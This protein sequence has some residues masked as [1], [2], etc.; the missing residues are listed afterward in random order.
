MNVKRY[1]V[2]RRIQ[3]PSICL[4]ESKHAS[5]CPVLCNSIILVSFV[6]SCR[7]VPQHVIVCHLKLGM[8]AIGLNSAAFQQPV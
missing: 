4:H 3:K 6:V 7:I 1:N 2:V 8:L 5:F